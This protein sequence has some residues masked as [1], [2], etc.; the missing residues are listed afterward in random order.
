MAVFVVG[1]ATRVTCLAFL[2][3]VRFQGRVLVLAVMGVMANILRYRRTPLVQAIL[4]QD[5]GSPLQR[6]KQHEKS[7]HEITHGA[8][9]R[10]PR[11]CRHL[12]GATVAGR[13]HCDQCIGG[14]PQRVPLTERHI[15]WDAVDS[16]VTALAWRVVPPSRRGGRIPS[17]ALLAVR[18]N[19]RTRHRTVGAKHA[20]VTRPRPEYD[21]ATLALVE[22]LAHVRRHR[23]GFRV[24]ACR[25]GERRFEHDPAHGLLPTKVEG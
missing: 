14:A 10:L 15:P 6:Q 4:R 8:D 13:T 19:R 16:A 3:P 23:L 5:S 2:P 21:M 9:C 7:D 24:T 12:A 22:P 1:N 18:L 20:A 11:T 25:T 17:G